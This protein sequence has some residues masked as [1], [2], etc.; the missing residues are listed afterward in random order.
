MMVNN[1][2]LSVDL[3]VKIGTIHQLVVLIV[4]KENQISAGILYLVHKKVPG[5][6][7]RK[8]E[9]HVVFKSVLTQGA[10]VAWEDIIM[11]NN[12][13]LL[14]DISVKIGQTHQFQIIIVIKENQISVE[15]LGLV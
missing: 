4:V 14:V 11:V 15:I 3:F 2:H 10:I 1:Q 7:H 9:K 13:K 6:T 12:L 8:D 5:V